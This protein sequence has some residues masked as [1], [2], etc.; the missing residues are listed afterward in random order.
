MTSTRAIGID[1]ATDPKNV[2]LALAELRDDGVTVLEVAVGGNIAQLDAWLTSRITS[3]E[4]VLIAVDAPLGWPAPLGAFLVEH[5][6]GDDAPDG[7]HRLF[8]RATDDC[9]HAAL[10]KRPL[11]VGADRIAR[12]AHAALKLLARL[13]VATAK[14]MRLAWSPG[15]VSETSCIEVY[16]AATLASR[17]ISAKGYKAKDGVRARA[18]VIEAIAPE[19][20]LS[21]ETRTSAER[22]DHVLDAVLCTLA[23]NDFL[24]GTVIPVPVQSAETARREGWIWA[25]PRSG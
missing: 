3:S 5:N 16:P 8:R 14:P 11:D 13:R 1:C 2:G 20:K 21:R 22:L 17:G 12:C 25:R 15:R 7:A 4:P 18:A 23:A 9:I 6:A 24:R 19:V 10:G